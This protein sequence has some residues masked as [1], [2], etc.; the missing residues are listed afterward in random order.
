MDT[1]WVLFTKYFQTLSS[2]TKKVINIFG[3][4]S[5]FCYIFVPQ[6]LRFV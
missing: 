3:V 1:T 2:I 6:K 4:V 5:K